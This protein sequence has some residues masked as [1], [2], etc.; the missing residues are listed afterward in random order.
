M[1]WY[2]EKLM[3]PYIKV[4]VIACFIGFLGGAMY[5]ATLLEQEFKAEEIVPKDSYVKG[6]LKGVN[7]YSVQTIMLG[8]YFHGVD[9]SNDDVQAQMFDYL[10]E[11][12]EID[13]IGGSPPFCWFRDFK[14]FE[15]DY[16]DVLDSVGNLT[17]NQKLDLALGNAAIQ[18]VYGGDIVR[19]EDGNVTASR[20][21][22]FIKHLD[23]QDVH[24]QTEM[25]LEQRDITLNH[26]GNQGRSEPAFFSFDIWYIIWVSQSIRFYHQGGIQFYWS[27][28]QT[29][30]ARTH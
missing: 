25:L 18:E 21:W 1:A 13:A 3:K 30:V 20:C 28:F 19:D 4:I 2:A 9:Q 16:A 17:F 26:P 7:E 8:A 11:L 24:A 5:S 6:F 22:L 27:S 12:S 15:E 29:S 14:K 10:T 23:M